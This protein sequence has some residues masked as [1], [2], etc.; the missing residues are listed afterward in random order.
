LGQRQLDFLESWAADWSGGV[1]M[2]FAVS[3]TRFACLQTMPAGTQDDNIDPK[4]PILPVGEYPPDDWMMADHDSGG[5]PQHGRNDAIR[6]WRKA[7]A[8]HLSGDQ[9]LGST[10]HYGVDDFRDGVY[11]VCTPA[12]SNLFPRR[13]FPSHPGKNTLLGRR[14]TGDYLDRFGNHITVLAVANPHQYP[15]SGF[16]GLRYWVTGYSIL[17]CNRETQK[18]NLIREGVAEVAHYL[19]RLKQDGEIFSED[20]WDTDFRTELQGTFRKELE[21][22]LSGEET[23]SSPWLK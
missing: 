19:W 15:G 21:S 10:S 12:I 17:R 13:W 16:P 14:N 22:G 4:L 20:Y 8:M 23:A 7:F 6:K 2:K 1:W 9:H 5:W 18:G 11:E 3:Q